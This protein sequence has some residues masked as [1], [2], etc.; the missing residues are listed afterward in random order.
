MKS[1]RQR[2]ALLLRG[3]LAGK[4]LSSFKAF[5]LIEIMVVVAIIAV[6]AAAAIPSLYGFVHKEGFRRTLSD[7][8]DACRSARSDATPRPARS[9]P[10]TPASASTTR[11][12]SASR[13]TSPWRA[14]TASTAARLPRRARTATVPPLPPPVILAPYK[15]A[16]GPAAGGWDRMRRWLRMA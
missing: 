6:I 3:T 7:V 1:R 14:A 13:S 16:D 5:T 9:R 4:R 2:K 12:S 10:A 11:L 15:P 8:L